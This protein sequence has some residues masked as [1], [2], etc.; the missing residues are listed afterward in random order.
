MPKLTDS[1]APFRFRVVKIMLDALE[2]KPARIARALNISQSTISTY[3]KFRTYDEYSEWAC[4]R[5][6]TPKISILASLW[7]WKTL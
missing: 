6:K 1:K 3:K 7:N 4:N 2:M 5:S